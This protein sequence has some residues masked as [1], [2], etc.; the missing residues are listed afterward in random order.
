MEL[1]SSAVADGLLSGQ[2]LS[3]RLQRLGCAPGAYP[4]DIFPEMHYQVS[5]RLLEPD[6]LAPPSGAVPVTGRRASI[7]FEQAGALSNPVQRARGLEQG[8]Q[9]FNVNCAM[10]HGKD[11]RG[12]SEVARRFAAAGFVPPVD[13][14]S[15]RAQQRSDG[16]L[17]WIVTHGLGNM[18]PF[19]ELLTE[20]QTWSVVHI[21][22][23]VQGR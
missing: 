22:R 15:A 11:G 7:T 12:E 1:D 8:R 16:Q 3:Q 18:P 9:V 10:C 13:F 6:R 17:Y 19:N 5:Q 20:D 23:E 4:I 14:T 21:I 2:G